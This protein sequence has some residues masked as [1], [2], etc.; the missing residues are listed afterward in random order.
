MRWC[1][2][3]RGVT[4]SIAADGIEHSLEA[5]EAAVAGAALAVDELLDLVVVP[6]VLD[7]LRLDLRPRLLPGLVVHVDALGRL[8]DRRVRSLAEEL[9]LRE[10]RLPG[11]GALGGALAAGAG[12]AALDRGLVRL[13]VALALLHGELG[14]LGDLARRRDLV[15]RDADRH[16]A[17]RDHHAGDADLGREQLRR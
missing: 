10:P 7:R 17:G 1:E 13:A 8:G 5:A 11:R 15:Q 16:H 6:V 9:A 14:A 3:P 4:G 2:W 12:V